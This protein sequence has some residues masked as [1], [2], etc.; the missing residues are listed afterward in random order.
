MNVIQAL[1]MGNDF[2]KSNSIKSYIIDSEILL[3][4]VLKIERRE[5]IL[6][7]TTELSSKNIDDYKTLLSKRS[8]QEPIVYLTNK[9]EFW[10]HEFI[11][12]KN[13]LIPRPET[14]FIVDECLKLTKNK[15]NLRLLDIGIGSGCI[16][17]SILY[18]REDFKGI[19]IDINK[20][21]IENSMLNAKK[22]LLD[23]RVKFIKSDIDNFNI[24]K[25]DIIVTNPPYINNIEY[26]NLDGCVKNYEPSLALKGGIDG[27]KIINKVI[28][29]SAVLIKKQGKLIIEFA[30]NQ[31]LGVEKILKAN[32]F[33]INKVIKDFSGHNRVIVSTKKN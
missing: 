7:Q 4:E 20:E 8:K 1:S 30:Y 5:I 9:K 28:K 3:S 33:F 11:I 27:L 6:N 21:A 31:K 15:S 22:L 13:V 17:L 16:L 32:G 25:Y 26:N 10:K 19:G 14:E 2:L 23:K 18:E 12:N 29:K 24:G